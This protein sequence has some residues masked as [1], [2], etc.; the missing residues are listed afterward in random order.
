MSLLVWLPLNGNLNNQGLSDL[1]FSLVNYANAITSSS[2][3]GKVVSGLYKRTTKET[4]DYIISNKSITLGGDVTM[5]CWAKVTGVGY[6]GTANGIFGQHGHLTGGLGITMKDVSSTDLRMSVNTGLYGDS[7]ASDRTYCTYYGSTNIYN[8]WHHLCLTYNSSTRQLRMY[9][10]GNLETITGYGSYITLAG[11]STVAR[12]II[13]FAWSTDHLGSNIPSYRPPCELNDVRVYDHCLSPKEVKEVAKGLVAHYQLKTPKTKNYLEGK[14]FHIYNNW[15]VTSSIAATGETY[16][17]YPVYRVTQTPTAASLNSFQTELWSHGVYQSSDMGFDLRSSAKW[18]YWLYARPVSHPTTTR[19]G[20]TASNTGNWVEDAPEYQGDGWYKVGQTRTTTAD[21]ADAI[22][23]SY[24]TSNAQTGVPIVIDFCG[25]HLLKGTNHTFDNYIE[26]F[27]NNDI[28]EDVSGYNNDLRIVGSAIPY[29]GGPRYESYHSFNQSGYFKKTDFNMRT[30]AFTIAFWMN[31]PVTTSAQHF[32][33]GTFNGWTTNGFG[34]WRNA[35]TRTK[36]SSLYKSDSVGSHTGLPAFEP[37]FGSWTHVAFV[38]TGTQGIVY[39]N[40]VECGRVNGGS[41]GPVY[42]PALYLGNSLYSEVSSQT[43]ESSMSDFRFYATAL[44]AA[45]VQELYNAP[46][47]LTKNGIMMA[48]EFIEKDVSTSS[49]AKNG[50]VAASNFSSEHALLENMKVKALTDGSKWA[51]IYHHDVRSTNHCFTSASEV[52]NCNITG[53][54]SKMGKV[55]NFKDT[56]GKY[57]FMLTYPTIKHYSPAGYTLLDCIEAT[58]QQY[59]NTGLWGTSDGTYIRGHRW[60][61]DIEM[62]NNIGHRQLMGY[63]GNGGE[64]WGL[65]TN[66]KYGIGDPGNIGRGGVR[67]TMVH[68]YSG[69]TAGGNTLWFD[70]EGLDVGDNLTTSQQYQLFCIVGQYNSYGC[71]AKLYRCKAFNH[72]GS[73]VRDYIPVRRDFD[74]AVGLYDRV[75]NKFYGNNGA[76]SF[77]AYPIEKYIPVDYIESTGTQYID[78]GFVP[79]SNTRIALDYQHTGDF[80]A[81]FGARKGATDSVFGAWIDPNAIYPH[82]GHVAYT[83]ATIIT[84]TTGRFLFL[85]NKQEANMNGLTS[86]CPAASFNSGYSLSLLAMNDAGVI[87]ERR[88][89]GRIYACKIFSGETIVRDF[90]PVISSLTNEAGLYDLIGGQFYRS[91]STVPFISGGVSSTKDDH[92]PYDFLEYIQSDGNQIIDTGVSPSANTQVAIQFSPTGTMDEKAIFG[93]TWATNGFFL[94]FYR[95]L[96]RWHSRNLVYD[97]LTTVNGKIYTCFCNSGININRTN[98]GVTANYGST[99]DTTNTIKLFST[100]NLQTQNGAF[101][102]YYCD[103]YEGGEVIMSL[104]PVRRKSDGAIGLYDS[105]LG[106]FFYNSGSGAFIAGPTIAP[107]ES[108]PVYNRWVQDSWTTDV[109]AGDSIPMRRVSTSWPTHNGPLKPANANT[110]CVYDCDHYNT[111]N[112]W[113]PIGLLSSNTWG[114]GYPAADGNTQREC[115]LWVRFD[116]HADV[117]PAAIQKGGSIAAKHFMET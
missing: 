78:T 72:A 102:L 1:K 91:K 10:D 60:E 75:E 39:K 107:K 19:I 70:R 14:G 113:A 58:G 33:V 83:Q 77:L 117:D 29:K 32:L 85:M 115:E 45:D 103:I 46:I 25:P 15:G 96:I 112:W 56:E 84:S 38:Y 93:S 95:N 35:G 17:G 61:F 104:H 108:I 2:S 11:N 54:Y 59:I 48:G 28:I 42:H 82:Y 99:A 44:S 34:M 105:I 62:K 4:A 101:K 13:L 92:C 87:D 86:S 36:Y 111:G 20:G 66:N 12:P 106:D 3:G 79:D 24:Y 64:Y 73:L 114:G 71:H 9:V 31:S 90:I 21:R 109:N 40:G 80:S 52:A 67:T 98:Y 116:K 89:E 49:I 57:E 16:R 81:L 110:Q 8:A 6:A 51:R 23:T 37:D 7:G 100:A 27:S 53:K 22:Y 69:G 88:S 68:D 94:M 74:G 26:H 97:C 41:N 5:C 30:N 43:S 55:T 50:V 18:S 65:Q 47:S 76:G 63:G